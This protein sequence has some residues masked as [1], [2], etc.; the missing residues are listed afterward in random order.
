MRVM[1][2]RSEV[3]RWSSTRSCRVEPFTVGD[4]PSTIT[5]ECRLP[6]RR[7]SARRVCFWHLF[8][9]SRFSSEATV[10][11]R[12]AMPRAE[13]DAAAPESAADEPAD[14]S[15]E[16]SD[17]PVALVRRFPALRKLLM[18]GGRRI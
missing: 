16:E 7:A 2:W 3:L 14:E 17:R 11:D 5:T 12:G 8:P 15:I 4:E 10:T 6:P 13:P 1:R 9:R 18:D